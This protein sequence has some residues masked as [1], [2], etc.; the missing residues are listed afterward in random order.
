MCEIYNYENTA[1]YV[2]VYTGECALNVM[3]IDVV[4]SLSDYTVCAQCYGVHGVMV[5]CMWIY[6]HGVCVCV[7]ICRA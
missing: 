6:V 1:G 4:E 5:L 2:C 7:C 3:C